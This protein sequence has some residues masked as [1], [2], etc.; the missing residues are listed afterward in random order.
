MAASKPIKLTENQRIALAFLETGPVFAD[1]VPA[2]RVYESLVKLGLATKRRNGRQLETNTVVYALETPSERVDRMM[3]HDANPGVTM[4][5]NR[6]EQLRVARLRTRGGRSEIRRASKRES[7]TRRF[8]ALTA[9]HVLAG[10][11]EELF[12]SNSPIST[13]E[14]D[15]DCS[16][17]L[18]DAV[19]SARLAISALH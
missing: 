9:A 2:N 3:P 8:A 14:D 10:H 11:M 4:A 16:P 15:P 1:A 17:S 6:A 13:C 5:V 7:A 19:K 12:I 18:R